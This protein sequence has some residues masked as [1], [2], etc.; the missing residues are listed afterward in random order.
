MSRESFEVLQGGIIKRRV[1]RRMGLFIDATGLDRAAR[2]LNRKVDLARLVSVLSSGIKLE[3]S[4]YYCLIPQEDDAR[5][6]AFLDAVER[7]GFEILTKRLPPK[8]VKRQVSMDVHI[9]A[10]LIGFCYGQFEKTEELAK[11]VPNGERLP[12]TTTQI[13]DEESQ[14]QIVS[15]APSGPPERTIQRILTVV[16][17]SREM[18]YAIYAAGQLGVETCL[19]DFGLYGNSD[20]W[21]GVDRWIDLSTSETIWR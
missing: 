20:A 10:D 11:V 12:D 14:S 2:R 21:K 8:G 15:I 5:Q 16:C 6:L 9:A 13:K 18:G 7:A 17:P 19:A 4:R 3:V 1:K